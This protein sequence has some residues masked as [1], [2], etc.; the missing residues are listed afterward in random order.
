MDSIKEQL[1]DVAAA[2][3]TWYIDL[4]T[5]PSA[6][7][8]IE[9]LKS[10]QKEYGWDTADVT[11]GLREFIAAGFGP[12]ELSVETFLSSRSWVSRICPC[13]TSV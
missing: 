6:H 4:D 11:K 9:K 8:V 2:L 1:D 10:L 13:Y 5:K 7:D 3:V 12:V